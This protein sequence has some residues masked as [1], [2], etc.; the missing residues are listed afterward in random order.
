MEPRISVN[1]YFKIIVD[2]QKPLWNTAPMKIKKRL[3]FAEIAKRLRDR[4]PLT[5]RSRGERRD[6]LLAASALN[7]DVTTRQTPP[8]NGQREYLVIYL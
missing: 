2:T 4:K 7:M 1:I 8:T 6:V 3:P 5:V